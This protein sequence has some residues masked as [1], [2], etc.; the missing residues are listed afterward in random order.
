MYYLYLTKNIFLFYY[1][2]IISLFRYIVLE[3]I[4]HS[5]GD[6]QLMLKNTAISYAVQQKVRKLFG[7]FG[8]AA[9]KDGFDGIILK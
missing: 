6:K 1:F 7:D 3:V 5:R 2:F 8:M 4:P 9:I